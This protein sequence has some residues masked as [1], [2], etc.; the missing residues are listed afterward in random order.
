[1]IAEQLCRTRKAQIF[2]QLSQ[3][4][5]LSF[6]GQ[7]NNRPISLRAERVQIFKHK[8]RVHILGIVCLSHLYD[9]DC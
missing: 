2:K 3:D 5:K 1:M 4:G 8:T 6:N 9:Y 7:C